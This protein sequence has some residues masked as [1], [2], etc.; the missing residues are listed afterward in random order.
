[1]LRAMFTSRAF[2]RPQVIGAQ[3]KSPVQLAVGTIRQLG[4]SI[5]AD[6][7]QNNALRMVAG[8]PADGAGPF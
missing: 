3:V 6:A 2:Y 5:P 7:M 1:M 8:L 4:M